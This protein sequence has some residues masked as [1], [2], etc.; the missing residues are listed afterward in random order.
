MNLDKL[1]R[2]EALD[3]LLQNHPGYVGAKN[4]AH[5]CDFDVALTLS[6]MDG[7]IPSW[8]YCKEETKKGVY[9]Y[10]KVNKI[11]ILRDCA[12]LIKVDGKRASRN[13]CWLEPATEE[14]YNSAVA[15]YESSQEQEA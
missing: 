6:V 5:L 4:I 11:N 14:E 9:D 13:L 15:E 7:F 8:G 3:A 12:E 1:A 2:S 10:F